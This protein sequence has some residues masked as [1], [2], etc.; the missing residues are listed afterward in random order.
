[1]LRPPPRTNDQDG[2][3]GL[4]RGVVSGGT[5]RGASGRTMVRPYGN[6][7]SR[8][9]VPPFSDTTVTVTVAPAAPLTVHSA[10]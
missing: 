2:G 1:M 5:S 6:L 10:S 7:V 3:G 4:F 8:V 9:T